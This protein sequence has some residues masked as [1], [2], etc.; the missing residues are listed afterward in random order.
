MPIIPQ[1]RAEGPAQPVAPG[2]ESPSGLRVDATTAL[3][4]IATLADS[5]GSVTQDMPN[6]PADLGQGVARGMQAIGEGIGNVGEVMFDI[7]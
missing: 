5:L 4:G 7:R 6:A 1:F 3:R 2:M